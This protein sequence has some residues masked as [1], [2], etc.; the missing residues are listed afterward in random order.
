[1]NKLE[2][3]NAIMRVAASDFQVSDAKDIAAAADV[4]TNI[5][6]VA[7]QIQSMIT[8][9]PDLAWCVDA[10]IMQMKANLQ[11]VTDAINK[12]IE[13]EIRTYTNF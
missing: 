7:E 10:N 4:I 11:K 8:T 6:G 3:T 13:M 2:L 9:S 12:K 5:E 1:M